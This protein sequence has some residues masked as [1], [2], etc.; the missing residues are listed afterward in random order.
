MAIKNDGTSSLAH[1]RRDCRHRIAFAP[2]YRRKAVYAKLRADIGKRIRRLCEHK[3]VGTVEAHAMPDRIHMLA[4]MPPKTGA[5]SLMG[6][7][8]GKTSLTI[9]GE[10]ANP[11]M[12]QRKRALLV[13]GPLRLRGGAE[14]DDRPELHRGPG[15]RG[16]GR[17]QEV[18]EGVQGPVYGRVRATKAIGQPSEGAVIGP[19]SI[20][21]Y[22]HRRK[23]TP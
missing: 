3:G 7:L 1:T 15:A 9:F 21:P 5:S 18:P 22:R 19:A 11:K 4:R 12:Q 6:H 14:Q 10:H 20:K 17:R 8:K 2:K 13:R 16:P 23:T